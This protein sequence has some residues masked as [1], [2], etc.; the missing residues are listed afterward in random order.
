MV[1][2]NVWPTD[3]ADGSVSSEARWRKMARYWTNTGVLAGQGGD[4]VPT[5]AFPNLTVKAGACWVDG[6]YCEL[7][8][9][10]VL[11]VTANGLAVV[12]FD[13]AA[14]TAQL[15]YLDGV[16]APNQSPTGTF[17]LPIAQISGSA[18][19]D[20]RGPYAK[21]WNLPWGFIGQGLASADQNGFG[22]VYTDITGLIVTFNAVTN[23]LYRASYQFVT[24]QN[25]AIGYQAFQISVD[26][27]IA[28]LGTY[29]PKPT[30]FWTITGSNLFVVPGGSRVVKLRGTTSGGTMNVSNTTAQG[31]L[32]IEDLGPWTA[33]PI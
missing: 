4:M 3:A 15:L 20:R 13:P 21:P 31:R 19:I 10:Q 22:A 26:G 24:L 27:A 25:T 5:L 14:N 12:R 6:H 23:R 11:A 1:A 28:Q 17:E 30:E 33:A 18:L 2:M 7:P 32:V 8:G 9:D 16:S 29:T